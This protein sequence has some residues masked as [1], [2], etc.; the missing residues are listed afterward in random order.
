[1]TGLASSTRALEMRPYTPSVFNYTI[2]DIPT[3]KAARRR[4]RFPHNVQSWPPLEKPFAG[5]SEGLNDKSDPLL[6]VPV[7]PSL[8]R[9]DYFLRF[10]LPI[11]PEPK[12]P[13]LSQ[14]PRDGMA[15]P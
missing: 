3:F 5:I 12:R 8:N 11:A 1:M 9:Q 10:P 14:H 2:P 15:I 7:Q 6:P 4:A 13:S